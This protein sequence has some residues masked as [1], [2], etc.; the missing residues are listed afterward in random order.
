MK[1]SKN[2]C[3]TFSNIRHNKGIYTIKC[4]VRIEH[5]ENEL[6]LNYID[7]T[8]LTEYDVL[9]ISWALFYNGLCEYSSSGFSSHI[10]DIAKNNNNA[11][12]LY[13]LDV[14]QRYHLNDVC[15]GT[16]EQEDYIESH[17]LTT[18]SYAKIL[19]F[20]DKE[21]LNNKY[22][23]GTK[24]LIKQIPSE[25]IRKLEEFCDQYEDTSFEK[26]DKGKIKERLNSL[27]DHDKLTLWNDWCSE[28]APDDELFYNNAEFYDTYIPHSADLVD[29][30]HD[31]EYKTQDEYVFFDEYGLISTCPYID[32]ENSPFDID[33][34]SERIY[35]NQELFGEFINDLIQL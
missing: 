23:Y 4:N 7:L 11:D 8:P 22:R 31:G 29:K 28:H 33:T 25:E 21:G 3:L 34:L 35:D 15:G 13:L 5:I 6:G 24:W 32:S 16:K 27:Q 1:G 12:L 26:V 20:L 14:A 2:K 19:S 30:I 18:Y 10:E 9:S 17:N